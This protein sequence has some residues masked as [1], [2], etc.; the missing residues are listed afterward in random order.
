MLSNGT[1]SQQRD[2]EYPTKYPFIMPQDSDNMIRSV[3]IHF[4]NGVIYGFRFFDK[5]KALVWQIGYIDSGWSVK[6]VVIAENDVVI[7]VVA[8]LFPG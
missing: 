1:R 3:D 5:E 6:T 7:G 8:K 4:F 2:E